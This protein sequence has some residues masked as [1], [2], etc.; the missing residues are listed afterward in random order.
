L[1]RD[2]RDQ[3]FECFVDRVEPALA[4]YEQPVFLYAYP[5]SEA[6]LARLCNDDP[7][8]AERFELYVGGLELCNAYGELS[9]PVEQRRRFEDERARRRS[10]GHTVYPLDERFLDAL[11]EGM[12]PAAG[13]ALGFDRL[14]MVLLDAA[15]LGDVIAFPRQRV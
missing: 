1:A 9:S 6:A 5:A 12:P 7:R 14:M 3:Y 15:T 8:W 11:V 10:H 13:N 2:N 4:E